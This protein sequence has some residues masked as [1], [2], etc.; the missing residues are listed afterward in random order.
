MVWSDQGD[1][2][3]S[4]K[5][6]EKP[7]WG[8]VIQFSPLDFGGKLRRCLM[9]EEMIKVMLHERSLEEGSTRTCFWEAL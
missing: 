5:N 4:R 8:E 3:R 9:G 2:L 6:M 1:H 7:G